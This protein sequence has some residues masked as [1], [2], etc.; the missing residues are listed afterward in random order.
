MI[1]I[2]LMP[3]GSLLGGAAAEYIGAPA[4]V[5]LFGLGFL[6]VA[7]L[8]LRVNYQSSRSDFVGCEASESR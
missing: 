5:A 1:F 3:I 4:T 6:L 8:Y 7:L 2:G